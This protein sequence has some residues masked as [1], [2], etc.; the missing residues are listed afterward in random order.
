[1][2]LAQALLSFTHYRLTHRDDCLDKKFYPLLIHKH[3]IATQK[4]AVCHIFI[5]RFVK[6]LEDISF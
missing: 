6:L 2:T 3:R 5:G 4:C 1:M